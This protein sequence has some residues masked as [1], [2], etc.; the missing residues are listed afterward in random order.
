[1]QFIDVTRVL[2]LAIGDNSTKD[3][4]GCTSSATLHY[5]EKSRVPELSKTVGMAIVQTN[6]HDFNMLRSAIQGS[7][8]KHLGRRNKALMYNLKRVLDKYGSWIDLPTDVNI[9]F[10]TDM[11]EITLIRESLYGEAL[12]FAT[13]PR[14]EFMKKTN[15]ITPKE[16]KKA[17]KD[18]GMKAS[19]EQALGCASC[20]IVTG[21]LKRCGRCK[22]VVYCGP[23]CQRKHWP[24][25]KLTCASQLVN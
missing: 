23:E 5:I 1:M 4:S 25:H 13:D 17:L 18:S 22:A 8:K 12:V 3:F 19:T 21:D 2:R 14:P 9:E 6:E 24:T 7:S 11:V 20:G 10:D 16:V 15:G